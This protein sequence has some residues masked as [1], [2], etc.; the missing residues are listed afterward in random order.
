VVAELVRGG[1]VSETV[2]AILSDASMDSA[3]AVV[4]AQV[5]GSVQVGAQK[6]LLD[7][8]MAGVER[9]TVS[10]AFNVLDPRVVSAVQKLDTKVIADLRKNVVTVVRK[11]A[12]AAIR[13]GVGPRAVAARMRSVVGLGPTQWEQVANY[14]KALEE[15]NVMRAERYIRRD[16]RFDSPLGKAMKEAKKEGRKLT[17][18]EMAEVK[19]RMVEYQKTLTP[20]KIDKMVEAYTNRRIGLNAESVARTATMDAMKEGQHLAVQQAIDIGAM[21]GALLQKTWVTVGDDRVRD[22]HVEMAGETV[23]WD[24][25]YSNFEFIP[26]ESTYGCRC[27]SHY[28]EK[29][30]Q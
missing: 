18:A 11:E 6:A 24:E 15:G 2:N 16:A 27:L 9:G 30:S 22:E 1:H 20:A 14:R 28:S 17:Q 4:R 5:L 19:S 23:G 3:A 25:P 8:G 21:D 7:V 12:E 26:G 13:L 10:I 29:R